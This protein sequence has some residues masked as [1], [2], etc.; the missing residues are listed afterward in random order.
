[1]MP[2]EDLEK[3]KKVFQVPNVT[4]KI[5]PMMNLIAKITKIHKLAISLLAKITK[6]YKNLKLIKKSTKLKMILTNFN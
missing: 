4:L 2:I 5:V 3:M 1:M 6:F